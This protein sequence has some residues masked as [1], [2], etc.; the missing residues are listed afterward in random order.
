[1]PPLL[2]VRIKRIYEP[3]DNDDGAKVSV[4]RV[5][6]RGMSKEKAALSVW[7]KGLA[8]STDLRHWFD[9]DGTRCRQSQIQYECEP[10]TESDALTKLTEL[11]KAGPVTLP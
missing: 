9:H 7:L 11:L 8:P 2:R 5:S 10:S 4:D 3:W 6:P 1:M